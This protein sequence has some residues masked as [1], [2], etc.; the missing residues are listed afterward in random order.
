VEKTNGAKVL[1]WIVATSLVVIVG[2]YIYCFLLAD[3]GFSPYYGDEF[4]YFQ[5]SKS[6]AENSSLNASFTYTGAG[7]KLLGADAHG[8]AYPLLYG[9]P[10]KLVGWH[11]PIIPLINGLVFSLA[12]LVMF[13]SEKKAKSTVNLQLI[14]VL[15][16]PVTLFYSFTFMPELIHLAGG[17]LLYTSTK[18]YLDTLSKP[19]Y[20][21]LLTSILILGFLRSTWFLAML[22]MLVIPGPLNGYLKLL[23]VV[24]AILLAFFHQHFLHEQVSN[25]FSEALR[26]AKDGAAGTAMEHLFFNLKRNVYFSLYYSEGWYYSIQ[27]ALFAILLLFALSYFRSSPLVRFGVTVSVVLLGFNL[28]LYK[29]YGWVELRI[30]TPMALFLML[31]MLHEEKFRKFSYGLAFLNILAFILIFPVVKTHIRLRNQPNVASV[32]VDLRQELL[33]TNAA[34]VYIDHETLDKLA[35]Y[36]LPV[37]N[38]KGKSIRYILPYYELNIESP[39]HRL[40]SPGQLRACPSNILC[41]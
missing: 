24:S 16:S 33:K 37:Q 3:R 19:D 20:L 27:K 34:L 1:G 22:G 13:L 18:K 32:P 9:L 41:Q 35:L 23:F 6:F 12:I 31:S 8:P 11:R 4:F 38:E 15:G 14:F 7:A 39:S 28:I 2:I 17:I 10:A 25:A 40:I 36:E 29:N 21:L 5:N 30:L 26:L